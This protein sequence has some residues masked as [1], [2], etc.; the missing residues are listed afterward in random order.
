LTSGAAEPSR[1]FPPPCGEGQGWG[2]P[3]PSLGDVALTPPPGSAFGRV[4]PPRKGEVRVCTRPIALAILP[5]RV[6]IQ[7]GDAGRRGTTLETEDRFPGVPR[8]RALRLSADFTSRFW[9]VASLEVRLVDPPRPCSCQRRRRARLVVAGGQG[10]WDDPLRDVLRRSGRPSRASPDAR[11]GTASPP[12][13]RP[14]DHGGSLR[15]TRVK[16]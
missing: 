16:D 14:G 9:P 13:T 1:F 2:V 15:R 7:E 11:R 5:A 4:R 12:P 10:S 3:A 8:H 6:E